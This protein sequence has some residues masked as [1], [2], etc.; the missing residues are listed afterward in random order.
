MSFPRVIQ[1]VPVGPVAREDLLAIAATTRRRFSCEAVIMPALPVPAHAFHAERDQHD[2]DALLEVLFD[3][4][5]LDVCRIVGVTELDLFAE[6][7]NFVFGYAH[8]RDRV[9]IFST[10]RLRDRFWGAADDAAAYAAR[11]EKAL[12]HEL[13]HT[14]Q[15]PHCPE[16]RCVMHQVEHLWQLDEL[17]TEPCPACDARIAV[18]ASRGVTQPDALF[19]LAGSYMRRRRYG[20]AVAAYTA[21]CSA[22]PANPHYANDLGVALLAAGERPAAARE[23]ERAIQLAPE[24]PHAYYNLGIVSREDGDP[25]AADRLFMEAIS[26]D[27]DVRQAHRYLGILHQDYFHDAQRAAAFFEGYVALGGDDVEVRR[28]LRLI[29]RDLHR[30]MQV[31]AETSRRAVLE[32]SAPV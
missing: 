31:L 23:F 17:A 4:L 28:R 14:F 20:R 15:A 24:L 22:E 19:E 27:A 30:C 1:I 6:G 26:R 25:P 9:A 13:G 29:Q 7:R 5:S 3:R 8:M 16:E 21:A 18:V 10:H 11:I 32:S 12:V 2:A